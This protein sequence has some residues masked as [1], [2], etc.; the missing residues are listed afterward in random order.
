MK[1]LRRIWDGRSIGTRVCGNLS[2]MGI[3]WLLQFLGWLGISA[4]LKPTPLF[5]YCNSFSDKT[6]SNKDE[7]QSRK[8][9]NLGEVHF[10]D[11][12]RHWSL[13]LTYLCAAKVFG[14]KLNST[15]NSS[16]ELLELHGNQSSNTSVKT[17]TKRNSMKNSGKPNK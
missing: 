13:N 16:D 8:L 14:F 1:V 12:T 5:N 4:I 3:L 6:N 9:R 10:D 15:L 2:G 7:K 11:S 17:V